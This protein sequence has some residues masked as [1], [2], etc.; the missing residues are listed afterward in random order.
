MSGRCK[1]VVSASRSPAVWTSVVGSKPSGADTEGECLEMENNFDVCLACPSICSPWSLWAEICKATGSEACFYNSFS[2]E[3]A[4]IRPAKSMDSLCSL[5]VEGE[6][7]IAYTVRVKDCTSA[8]SAFPR[9]CMDAVVC[10]FAHLTML[11][12]FVCYAMAADICPH[13]YVHAFLTLFCVFCVD[14][15]T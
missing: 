5:P 4:T 2:T 10:F 6:T 13:L 3:K 7:S 8:F 14:A 15:C 11:C 9:A 1:A 12:I